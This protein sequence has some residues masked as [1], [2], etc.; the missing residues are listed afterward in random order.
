[1]RRRR[2]LRH[3]VRKPQEA[4]Q[5]VSGA[6]P[7]QPAPAQPSAESA[8]LSRASVSSSGTGPLYSRPSHPFAAP[9]RSVNGSFTSQHGGSQAS[10]GRDAAAGLGLGSFSSHTGSSPNR[11]ALQEGRS[12]TSLADAQQGLSIQCNKW[13][14]AV[15]N[16]LHKAISSVEGDSSSIARDS[17]HSDDYVGNSPMATGL[18]RLSGTS[19]AFQ[20]SGLSSSSSQFAPNPALQ[21]VSGSG[22]RLVRESTPQTLGTAGA[23][24]VAP[25]LAQA[26]GHANIADAGASA[27]GSSQSRLS[28]SPLFGHDTIQHVQTQDFPSAEEFTP[29]RSIPSAPA[30]SNIPSS[31]PNHGQVRQGRLQMSDNTPLAAFPAS[32]VAAGL[33][34]PGSS[35]SVMQ[36]IDKQSG[37]IP[38]SLTTESTPITHASPSAG[39]HLASEQPGVVVASPSEGMQSF[40]Q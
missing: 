38:H 6:L 33:G 1:M 15:V 10:P 35:Q 13:G 19:Q 21:G 34:G 20:P 25:Q 30:L 39:H 18:T 5:V 8:V 14:N 17:V 12:G 31:S 28:N 16:E 9:E 24:P 2:W 40:A 7:S 22:N 3:R 4:G 37:I 36:A 11:A 23:I 29:E 32:T 26:T 27:H